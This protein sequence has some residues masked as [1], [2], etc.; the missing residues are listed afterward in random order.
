[1]SGCG[2]LWEEGPGLL[3]VVVG[4]G[5]RAGSRKEGPKAGGRRTFM[6]VRK[7]AT[8]KRKPRRDE[9]LAFHS[10]KYI[11]R[12]EG[13]HLPHR[14][15][16]RDRSFARS[17]AAASAA[18]LGSTRAEETPLLGACGRGGGY[19]AAGTGESGRGCDQGEQTRG[20]DASVAD[21]LPILVVLFND[22]KEALEAG[23]RGD[24]DDGEG[25][26]HAAGVAGGRDELAAT[27]HRERRR[28][29]ALRRVASRRDAPLDRHLDV[30]VL[31]EPRLDVDLRM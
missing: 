22:Q 8:R 10:C 31:C 20:R 18:A 9:I 19:T 16:G 15:G 27:Q 23:A 2:W 14:G 11:L 6:P 1:M 29:D 26:E 30:A 3:V 13:P 28:R 21:A 17:F 12:H 4:V 7:A 25:D 24:D 5:P